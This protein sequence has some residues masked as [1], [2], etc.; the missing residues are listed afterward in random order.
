MHASHRSIRLRWSHKSTRFQA[1]LALGPGA[2]HKNKLII[3]ES[4]PNRQTSKASAVL[5]LGRAW[6]RGMGKPSVSTEVTNRPFQSST[7]G[8][9]KGPILQTFLPNYRPVFRD[10]IL[11]NKNKNKNNKNQ[12]PAAPVTGR[13]GIKA[14][15]LPRRG[16]GQGKNQASRGR[17][18]V[19]RKRRGVKSSVYHA[20][21]TREWYIREPRRR[22]TG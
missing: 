21:G 13:G 15:R 10:V 12:S 9:A 22:G 4:I 1:R 6:S 17:G 5:L 7:W 3:Q 14:K 16:V 18:K 20:C 19:A 2:S 8:L 11:K